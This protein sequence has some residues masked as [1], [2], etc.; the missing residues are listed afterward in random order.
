MLMALGLA[1]PALAQ[2]GVFELGTVVVTGKAQA[3]AQTA[4]RVMGSETIDTLGKDTV[5][6]AVAVL[7]GA[8]LTR[9]SRNEDT[10]SLR[11]FDV[12]QVPLYIDGVP[13][14]VP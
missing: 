2:Q 11:G 10:V 4:E 13:L 5:G 9:N 8:S 1:T 12:R 7:P 3:A 14:Y 6:A